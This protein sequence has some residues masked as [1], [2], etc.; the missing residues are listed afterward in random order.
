[1]TMP[2]DTSPSRRWGCDQGTTSQ[3]NQ[4]DIPNDGGELAQHVIDPLED[5]QRWPVRRHGPPACR[6]PEQAQQQGAARVVVTAGTN[7]DTA[8][9]GAA[10]KNCGTIDGG[11]QGVG[12]IPVEQDLILGDAAPSQ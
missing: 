1:M 8:E 9:I 3:Q 5:S 4:K 12:R 7:H 10:S 11:C 6:Y 2:Y